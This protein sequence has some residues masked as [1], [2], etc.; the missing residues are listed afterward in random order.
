MQI[1]RSNMHLLAFFRHKQSALRSNMNQCPEYYKG[2]SFHTPSKSLIQ[3][4]I[5]I[6]DD[7]M[8]LQHDIFTKMILMPQIPQ[9]YGRHS[10]H[11]A[12]PNYDLIVQI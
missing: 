4:I 8:K 5:P 7:L 10:L 9:L 2:A 11:Y 12:A 3:E 6:H 1:S